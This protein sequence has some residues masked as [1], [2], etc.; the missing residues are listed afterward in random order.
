MLWR[1]QQLLYYSACALWL[2]VMLLCGELLTVDCVSISPSVISSYHL[3]E[4]FHFRSCMNH[5]IK[6]PLT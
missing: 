6:D 3:P 1:L 2:M 5:E 4:Q